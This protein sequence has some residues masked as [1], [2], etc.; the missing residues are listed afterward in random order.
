MDKGIIE[1]KRETKETQITVRLLMEK[2]TEPSINTNLP[3]FNHVLHSMAFHG[4][5]YLAVDA[6]GDIEVDAHHLVEDTGIVIGRALREHYN[7]SKKINR[8]GHAVIPMDDALSEAVIDVCERPFLVFDANFPQEY[9]GSFHMPLIKEYLLALVNSAR[10]NLHARCL[11]GGNSH[12]M[13]EALF[14]ALGKALK[15]AYT[16]DSR[17]MSTKGTI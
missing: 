15:T 4:R 7:R 17:D 12:H 6:Q 8:Y 1:Q 10:I 9:S 3:F 2:D 13:A 16:P 11:Y 14:K 5:F